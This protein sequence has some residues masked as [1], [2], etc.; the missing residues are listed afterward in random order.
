MKGL[1]SHSLYDL[2]FQL[3][4]FPPFLLGN[5]LCVDFVHGMACV[6]VLKVA[7]GKYLMC[8]CHSDES[9]KNLTPDHSDPSI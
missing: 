3:I 2:C 7:T 1:L 8:V 5:I 9:W 6:P 4:N